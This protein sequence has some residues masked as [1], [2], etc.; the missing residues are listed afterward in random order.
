MGDIGVSFLSSAIYDVLK[1][2][3]CK[4]GIPLKR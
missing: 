4:N 2:I 1:F 3:F